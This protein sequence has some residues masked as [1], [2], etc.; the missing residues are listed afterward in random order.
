M[1]EH[2]T[3][4]QVAVLKL[5][6]NI[7][8]ESSLTTHKLRVPPPLIGYWVY[9][10]GGGWKLRLGMARRPRWLERV[11]LK[12]CFGITWEDARPS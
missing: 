4:E 11:V 7:Q 2:S 8:S 5:W 9:H 10:Q 12:C 3:Q 6:S 1:T